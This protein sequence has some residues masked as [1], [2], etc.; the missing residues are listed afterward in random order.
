VFLGNALVLLGGGLAGWTLARR[1]KPEPTAVPTPTAAPE[2]LEF[3]RSV[4][5]KASK[6]DLSQLKLALV[7]LAKRVDSVQAKLGD[8][9]ADAARFHGRLEAAPKAVLPAPPPVDLK[10]LE[11]RLDRLTAGSK[12]L[13]SVRDDVRSVATQLA[14]I[15]KTIRELRSE[16]ATLPKQVKQAVAPLAEQPPVVRETPRPS[17]VEEGIARVKTLLN[18]SKFSDARDACAKL[19]ADHS[20]DA[21]I[22]YLAAL[23]SGFA[24]GDWNGEGTRFV[25]RGIER[26]RAGTPSRSEIDA[27]VADLNAQQ[28][29]DWLKGWRARG[30]PR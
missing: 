3:A 22:W 19:A 4:E 10:P 21:R 23:A 28:A 17:A 11:S 6:E 26:E 18:D 9:T 30:L 15:D 1:E 2:V 7:D 5:S 8:V 27:V 13:D 16:V 20:D 24:T 12:N 14:A 25:S 29:K